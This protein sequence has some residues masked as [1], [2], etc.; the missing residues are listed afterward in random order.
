MVMGRIKE[1]RSWWKSLKDEVGD[2]KCPNRLS[3][4]WRE[5]IRMKLMIGGFNRME[6]GRVKKD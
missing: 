6:M 2:G 5:S 1:G 3:W 4:R